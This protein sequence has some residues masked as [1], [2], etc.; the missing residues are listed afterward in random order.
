[1]DSAHYR[2]IEIK[3][4]LVGLVRIRRAGR[5]L[6]SK[7]LSEFPLIHG[8]TGVI[9]GVLVLGGFDHEHICQ[10][11]FLLLFLKRFA[12]RKGNCP[13]D[14]SDYRQHDQQFNQ[15]HSQTSEMPLST[16]S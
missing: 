1:M 10:T 16:V 8:L 2:S 14:R 6:K 7:V 13:R 11:L 4:V 9:S 5:N 15:R 12:D 3:Q